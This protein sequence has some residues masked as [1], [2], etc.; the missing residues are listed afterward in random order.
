MT[1]LSSDCQGHGRGHLR[2]RGLGRLGGVEQD[3]GGGRQ[4]KKWEKI[5]KKFVDSRFVI[6]M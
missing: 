3:H 4:N 6:D 5:G 1:Q 2:P